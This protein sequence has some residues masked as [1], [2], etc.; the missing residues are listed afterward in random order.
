MQSWQKAGMN[1]QQ[2]KGSMD[3]RSVAEPAAYERAN[4]MKALQVIGNLTIIEVT[5]SPVT[6]FACKLMR[7][8]IASMSSAGI[9][10]L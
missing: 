10:T 6:S 4:Y 5:E 1:L 7:A 3:H 9:S 2:L 8:I